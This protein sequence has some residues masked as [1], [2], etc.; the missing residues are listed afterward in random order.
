M[1]RNLRHI[2]CVDDEEDILEVARLSLEM[3]GGFTVSCCHNGK[4]A[5]AKAP[6]IAPDLILLDVMM[7]EIDGPSTLRQLRSFK[8]L[9]NTPVVFMTAKVQTSEVESYLKAGAIG[10]LPKPFDPMQLA[11]QINEIWEKVD[12]GDA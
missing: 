12:A 8:E 3:V 1:K 10:V 5:I 2:L 11:A 9:E 6:G 4:E 7:P